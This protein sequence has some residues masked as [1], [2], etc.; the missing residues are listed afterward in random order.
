MD[1][2]EWKNQ[3]SRTHR[4]PMGLTDITGLAHQSSFDSTV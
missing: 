3:T 1:K 2:N 4:P